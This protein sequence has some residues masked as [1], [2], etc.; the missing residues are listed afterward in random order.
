[1]VPGHLETPQGER[2]LALSHSFCNSSSKKPSQTA[3]LLCSQSLVP[4]SSKAYGLWGHVTHLQCLALAQCRRSSVVIRWVSGF[5]SALRGGISQR[6]FVT[7]QCLGF[8]ICAV[9]TIHTQHLE[10][11]CRVSTLFGVW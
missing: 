6:D 4:R 7:A 3:S 1:M 8:P 5:K 11:Q 2:T 10:S 9:G